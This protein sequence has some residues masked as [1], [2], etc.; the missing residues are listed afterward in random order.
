[1]KKRWFMLGLAMLLLTGCAAG[2][3]PAS[4]IAP[5]TSAAT[6]P[7]LP[8]A[9]APAIPDGFIS[10]EAA[11]QIAYAYWN[12]SPGEDVS[13]GTGSAE[14]AKGRGTVHF[15]TYPTADAPYYE[16]IYSW[17]VPGSGHRSVLDRV[18]IH[19]GTGETHVNLP[20]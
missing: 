16:A 8:S 14:D 9:T 2:E 1:M 18:W 19:A 20:S 15:A 6:T 11:L 10:E 7:T 17:I 13:V 4:P 5:P 3:S 12:F